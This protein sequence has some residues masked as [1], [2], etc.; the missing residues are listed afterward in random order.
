MIRLR[1]KYSDEDYIVGDRLARIG[2]PDSITNNGIHYGVNIRGQVFDNL[3]TTGLQLEDWLND[4]HC[5]SEEFILE[6][7]DGFSKPFEVQ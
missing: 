2:V 7:L 6:E 5:P 1:T 4:F 3:S